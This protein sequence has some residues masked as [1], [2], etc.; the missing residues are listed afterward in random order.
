MVLFF[1][2][3]AKKQSIVTPCYLPLASAGVQKFTPTLLTNQN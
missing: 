1:S 2:L 3:H